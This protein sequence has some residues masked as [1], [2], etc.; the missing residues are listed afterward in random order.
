[1]LTCHHKLTD[2]ISR[3]P[4]EKFPRMLF[5]ICFVPTVLRG[6]GACH[7]VPRSLGPKAG[8][9][10]Y[11]GD[12]MQWQTSDSVDEIS[13]YTPESCPSFHKESDYLDQKRYPRLKAITTVNFTAKSWL[14]WT[15]ILSIFIFIIFFS[16]PKSTVEYPSYCLRK[17]H[18]DV[19]LCK[20][21]DD[22]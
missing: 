1:M 15:H 7:S 8:I 19:F 10:W 6:Y 5:E 3:K 20:S 17:F 4:P 21:R 14:Y 18:L 16:P 22:I 9:Q 12:S 13:A 11:S 2:E